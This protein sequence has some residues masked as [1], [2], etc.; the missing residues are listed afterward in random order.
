MTDSLRNFISLSFF[1][2]LLSIRQVKHFY[3]VGGFLVLHSNFRGPRSDIL[4]PFTI[5]LF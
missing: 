2:F 5:V 1:G 3:F 4:S